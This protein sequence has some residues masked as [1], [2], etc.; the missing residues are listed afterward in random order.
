MTAAC[1]LISLS[2]IFISFFRLKGDDSTNQTIS[3]TKFAPI[4]ACREDFTKVKLTSFGKLLE[5]TC[6]T[7]KNVRLCSEPDLRGAS[8]I[9][10]SGMA[11]D[12]A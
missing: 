5:K 9:G 3:K 1:L 6:G 11:P 2:T 10:N 4:P 7:L 12:A 8:G